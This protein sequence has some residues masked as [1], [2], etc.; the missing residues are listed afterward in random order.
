M[1]VKKNKIRGLI[2][3]SSFHDAQRC[4]TVCRTS[5]AEILALLDSPVQVGDVP[6]VLKGEV[7]LDS[8]GEGSF[9]R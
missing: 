5:R 2:F 7:L 3:S 4:E 8:R 9:Q 6:D 1:N